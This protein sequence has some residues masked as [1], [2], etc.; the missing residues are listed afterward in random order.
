MLAVGCFISFLCRADQFGDVS[1]EPSAI[2]TGNTYHGYAEMRVTL[3]NR[4]SGRTHVVTLVYPN[5]TYGNYGNNIS[6][7]SRSATLEPGAREVVSLLQLPL[8]AQGDGS[9]RVEVDNRREGE[10]RAPNANNHC[11]YYSRGGQA[12]TV[13]I[14]RNLDFD[15]VERLFQANHGAFTAAMAIGAPDARGSGYQPTTWMP[16]TRRGGQTNWLELDYAT[17][18]TVDKI[19]IYNTQSPSSSGFVELV[20]VSGTNVARIPMA[21]GRSTSS[22]SGWTTEFLFASTSV[23]V[24]TVRL[25]FE[26]APPY[27]IAID[28]VQISGPSGSQWAADARASSDNSA[29]AGSYTRGR[30]MNADSVESLRAES[31]TSEWSDNWLAYSPFDAVVLNAADMSSMPPAVLGA[32]GDYLRAGG[33]V[34]LSGKTDLPP[35]WHPWRN[36]SLQG[37]LDYGIGFGRCFAFNSENPSALDPKSVQTVRDA[38][39]NAANY[40]QT[41][42]AD[43]G[44]ANSVLPIVENL[45]IPTRGIVIIMLAFVIIIGPVNIIYLNR[46]KRR[47]WM[48]WTIPA[49]SFATTLLVFAYSLLREGITPDTRIVGLTLL[50]QTSHRAATIGGTAFYCPLTPSAGLHFD[51]ETEAAPLV[52]IG[53]GSGTAREVDWTQSQHLQRGWVSARVPAYF[54]LRKSEMRR[55]R[56]Q[57]VNEN[58]K[59]QIVNGL[60]APIK[61]LWIADAHMN[62]YQ[63]NSIA[64]GQKTGLIPSKPTQQSQK[65]GPVGL[66]HNIGLATKADSL[67]DGAGNFLME[68]TYIAVLDGNPFIENAL[69]RASSPKRTKSSAIVFGIIESPEAQ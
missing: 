53:Y 40:W 28:A 66:W 24:K 36:Q 4:S 8:P 42:P 48:L 11:N 46:R 63:A 54:H 1:V 12:A 17:P 61:S 30:G 56:I 14:S 10:V 34:I 60:G 20:G 67:N 9:I 18:Q 64:A 59:L 21:S 39:R 38:V 7:L 3:E 26:K 16:D 5:N 41:L 62:I 2:Y 47:T 49:I 69:G 55:E 22:G 44:S 19:F 35:A 51:F 6:R 15:A 45:K 68:N 43:N 31:P 57:I 50:D 58:G 29:S 32:I 23:P 27:N 33:N 25:N 52:R 13:F 65:I 37:G